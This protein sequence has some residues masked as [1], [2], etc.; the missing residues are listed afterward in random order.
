MD[1]VEFD[2]MQD[3]AT[4]IVG[5][6]RSGTTL[7]LNLLDHHPQLVVFPYETHFFTKNW[8]EADDVADAFVKQSSFI[9]LLKQENADVDQFTKHYNE[10]L[11]DC[12][13]KKQMLLL[14]LK[15]YYDLYD[16]S[17]NHD[18]R[19]WVEKTPLHIHHLPKFDS[20]F[21]KAAKYIYI[22]RDPRD[23]YTSLREAERRFTG[24]VP[25]AFCRSW[26]YVYMLSSFFERKFTYNQWLSIKYE[27]LVS[28]TDRILNK[29]CTFLE[30]DYS[31]VLLSQTTNGVKGR[32]GS[33]FKE[34]EIW[35]I[36]SAPIGRFR[37]HLTE[38]EIEGIECLLHDCMEVYGYETTLQTYPM[39][40]SF[41]HN[42]KLFLDLGRFYVD[43]LYHKILR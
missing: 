8:A 35:G 24:I 29:I 18:K 5:F 30:I 27:D 13:D 2:A 37:E 1:K 34:E 7:L 19:R 14:L 10:I 40:M 3:M 17:E 11:G 22:Y 43:W 21:G 41:K 25:Q 28:N 42:T 36:S 39:K 32:G 16:R 23:V 31:D 33:S 26:R 6:P 12:R 20:F 4:L 38:L 9:K 15:A